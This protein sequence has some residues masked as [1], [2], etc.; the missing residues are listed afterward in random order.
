[1]VKK[2]KVSFL[3][4][5]FFAGDRTMTT[6]RGYEPAVAEIDGKLKRG[7]VIDVEELRK[8]EF[9]DTLLFQ[10]ELDFQECEIDLTDMLES[11]E[12]G[13]NWLEQ[14]RKYF[15]GCFKETIPMTF[16]ISHLELPQKVKY[17]VLPEDYFKRVEG[18]R[19]Y[20]CPWKF[21][22]NLPETVC[23]QK[24]IPPVKFQDGKWAIGISYSRCVSGPKK[25]FDSYSIEDPE[26]KKHFSVPG[27]LLGTLNKSDLNGLVGSSMEDFEGDLPLTHFLRVA[28]LVPISLANKYNPLNIRV[29]L[30]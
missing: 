13:K 17:S 22:E 5:E 23:Y 7:R 21:I 12:D 26:D 20:W 25:V 28:Y 15:S 27:V 3:E 1:M 8:S 9:I 14:H 30:V 16:S 10:T 19:N 24:I 18:G 11:D 2:I 29:E 6:V 4:R